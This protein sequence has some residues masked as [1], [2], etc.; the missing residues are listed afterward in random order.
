MTF[1]ENIIDTT[2]TTITTMI[3]KMMMMMTMMMMMMMMMVLIAGLLQVPF[4]LVI[5]AECCYFVNAF[6][7]SKLMNNS[8]K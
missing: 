8:R 3:W 5:L 7:G 6:Y 1:A 2:T 4:D